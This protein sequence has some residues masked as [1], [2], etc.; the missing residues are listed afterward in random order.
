VTG[1]RNP[2]AAG[3]EPRSAEGEL[4]ERATQAGKG[5]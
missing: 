5:Q 3:K 2:P 1:F 4:P